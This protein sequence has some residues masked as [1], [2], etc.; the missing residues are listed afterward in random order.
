[1][2]I[3]KKPPRPH[4]PGEPILH[5]NHPRPVTR[6]ELLSAGLLGASGLVMAPAW[7]A[8]IQN[9]RSARLSSTPS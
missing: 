2:F 7:L 5:D 3:Q 9:W 4:A 6:R 8:A 1:M